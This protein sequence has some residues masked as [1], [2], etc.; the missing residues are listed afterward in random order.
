MI[1][2]NSWWPPQA[3]SAYLNSLCSGQCTLVAGCMLFLVQTWDL[4]FLELILSVYLLLEY[5]FLTLFIFVHVAQP[6]IHMGITCR[7]VVMTLF[8]F[9]DMAPVHIILF[10]ALL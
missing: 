5:P 2:V 8:V 7:A 3:A 6:W 4:L 1:H 10:Q 9:T